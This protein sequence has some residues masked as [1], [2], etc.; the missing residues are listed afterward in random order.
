MIA[1]KK[2]NNGFMLYR[3]SIFNSMDNYNSELIWNNHL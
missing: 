1:N 3:F 2:K